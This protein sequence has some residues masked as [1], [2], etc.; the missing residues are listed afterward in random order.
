MPVYAQL[1]QVP[2]ITVD[3]SIPLVVAFEQVPL[4]LRPDARAEE[5]LQNIEAIFLNKL[6]YVLGEENDQGEDHGEI[7][8]VPDQAEENVDVC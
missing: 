1:A 3:D 6:Y 2:S 8:Q 7:A 5:K 4:L